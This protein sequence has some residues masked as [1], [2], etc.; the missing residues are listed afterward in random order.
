MMS[1]GAATTSTEAQRMAA[2][3]RYDILDSPPD[4]AFDRITALAARRFGVP[5][6]IISIVDED[7]IWFKSRHGLPE[8]KQIGRDPGLCASAILS[9]DPHILTD[10]SMDPRS[11][12]NPLVAGDFGLRF[13]AGVPLTTSDGHNLGTLCVI[14]KQPRPI[15]EDQIEDLKDLASLVMD[16]LEFRI[17]AL[18]ALAK[19]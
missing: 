6:S 11:L 4:G 18:R 15:T 9:N 7:R 5:I 19:A 1:V 13:Y 8:V 3:R 10:A 12:A 16:Q 14:D 2:V 17:S